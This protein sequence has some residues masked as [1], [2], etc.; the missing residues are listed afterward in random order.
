M[1]KSRKTQ[2]SSVDRSVSNGYELPE[3]C[4]DWNFGQIN[5]SFLMLETAL[6][7]DLMHNFSEN[8]N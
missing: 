8:T 4:A 5:F 7:K 1:C 3:V 2:N 6:R